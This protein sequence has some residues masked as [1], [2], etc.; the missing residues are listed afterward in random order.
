[1]DEVELVRLVDRGFELAALTAAG[2][3]DEGCRR[4]RDRDAAVAR[5]L[6]GVAPVQHD[7]AAA[8]AAAGRR[9][10]DR[11]WARWQHAPERGPAGVAQRRALSTAQ[12]GGHEGA[13]LGQLRSPHG[14]DAPIDAVQPPPLD[15]MVD[16]LVAEA[17]R[18]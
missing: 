4:G 8:A 15:A 11:P 17:G 14:V 18:A 2:E 3:V 1:M 12:N 6:E 9:Y 13:E 5:D 7:A 16:G 10:V